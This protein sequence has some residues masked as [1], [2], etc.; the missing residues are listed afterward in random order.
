[1]VPLAIRPVEPRHIDFNQF[2][3]LPHQLGR[4]S[5]KLSWRDA[6]FAHLERDPELLMVRLWQCVEANQAGRTAPSLDDLITDPATQ[7]RSTRHQL[8]LQSIAVLVTLLLTGCVIVLLLHLSYSQLVRPPAIDSWPSG[9][10]F[11]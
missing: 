5:D 8:S 7:S 6:I 1:M 10:I 3:V 4:F 11:Y 2:Y 9:L